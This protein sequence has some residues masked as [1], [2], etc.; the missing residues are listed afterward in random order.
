MTRLFGSIR[1]ILQKIKDWIDWL[2]N[3]FKRTPQGI[4]RDIRTGKIYEK[5]ARRVAEQPY[6]WS[7][8]ERQYGESLAPAS[9]PWPSQA[10][11]LW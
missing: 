9:G 2:V 1:K 6:L 3:L 11:P 5:H 4:A 8:G 7:M 10:A